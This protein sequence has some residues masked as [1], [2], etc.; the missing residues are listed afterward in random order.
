MLDEVGGADELNRLPLA[1]KVMR[2]SDMR[3]RSGWIFCSQLPL[4]KR[5]GFGSGNV[6]AEI[7]YKYGAQLVSQLS[8]NFFILRHTSIGC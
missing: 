8:F 7:E 1:K 6:R 3:R 4:L 2:L 5:L